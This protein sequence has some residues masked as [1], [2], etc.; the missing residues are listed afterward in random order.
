MEKYGPAET[1]FMKVS[2][3]DVSKPSSDCLLLKGKKGGKMCMGKL[4]KAPNTSVRTQKSLAFYM[5]EGQVFNI[6][7]PRKLFSTK[8][9]L[10]GFWIPMFPMTL[11]VI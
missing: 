11:S 3:L 1:S 5:F 10:K 6:V 4:F 2:S 9:S 8:S 7:L